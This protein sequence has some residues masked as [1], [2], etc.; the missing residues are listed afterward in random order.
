MRL[1]E[2]V[3]DGFTATGPEFESAQSD[4]RSRLQEATMAFF[5]ATGSSARATTMPAC[6]IA[7]REED[8]TADRPASGSS[9]PGLGRRGEHELEGSRTR[10][11]RPTVPG[12][13]ARSR[14]LQHHDPLNLGMAALVQE[15]V[16]AG[17]EDGASDGF[18]APAGR[19]HH[20]A[21][22]QIVFDGFED[23][24]EEFGLGR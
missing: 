15:G 4:E 12:V 19:H 2:W 6:M 22:R 23:G 14:S 11:A 10:N 24:L 13:P 1:P 8:A 18:A 9:D 16:E 7:P 3:R 17:L 21:V 5:A 20:H